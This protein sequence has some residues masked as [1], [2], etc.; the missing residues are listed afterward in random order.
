MDGKEE[1]DSEKDDDVIDGY[2]HVS[3]YAPFYEIDAHWEEEDNGLLA[4]NVRKNHNRLGQRV[5]NTH[6]RW[7]M[8]PKKQEGH[9]QKT[10][11]HAE[12][13]LRPACGKFIY[14]TRHLPDVCTSF[15][16][17]L[18]NQK[19]GTYEHDFDTFARDWMAGDTIP[20]G[21]P[22]HHLLS[23]AM[24]FADNEYC[25]S[26]NNDD[27]N[28]AKHSEVKQRPLL[29]VSYEKLKS[30][31]RQ[32]VLRIMDFL[33]LD[34]ISMEVLDN[35]LLPTFDFRHMKVN[36]SKFQPKSVTWLNGYQF[37]RRGESG[38][39][40]SMFMMESGTTRTTSVDADNCSEGNDET[41]GVVGEVR[42]C[43]L[44]DTFHE[45]VKD[46]GYCEKIE[47]L[48]VYSG[49]DEDTTEVF[50]SLVR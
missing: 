48:K 19:E 9:Q 16:H 21:S 15:Y 34:H 46:E 44:L 43:T 7:D 3:D 38:D 13:S 26:R 42:G 24:R 32:E 36:S 25:C 35:E 12:S 31:L 47:N 17:H 50:I 29:L 1:D 5:F 45:W 28:A 22:L 14:V 40:K 2:E 37:L 4:E 39:G 30:N 41:S 6:L 8:L 18:S 33:N 11:V 49:L 23:F 10:Q 20:F 27:E